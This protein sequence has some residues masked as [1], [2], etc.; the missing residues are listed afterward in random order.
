MRLPRSGERGQIL[1]RTLTYPPGVTAQSFPIALMDDDLRE[2]N[3]QFV[4]TL[5]NPDRAALDGQHSRAVVTIVD[6]D[7][8]IHLPIVVRD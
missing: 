8:L 6:D 2:G 7:W 3:E 5:S 1:C 4:L